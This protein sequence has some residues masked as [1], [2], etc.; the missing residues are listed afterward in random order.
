MCAS[1]L[2]DESSLRKQ[3]FQFAEAT[4]VLVQSLCCNSH[5]F[6]EA[7]RLAPADTTKLR[8]VTAVS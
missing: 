5:Y 1:Q 2:P 6:V 4:Q 3:P 8:V 7:H